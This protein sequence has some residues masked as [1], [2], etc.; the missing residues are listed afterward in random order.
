MLEVGEIKSQLITQ[1]YNIQGIFQLLQ[2][3]H[4]MFQNNNTLQTQFF[5]KNANFFQIF[6]KRFRY[7]IKII[8]ASLS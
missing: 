3:N 2:G 8:I 6:A 5:V 7:R 1:Q 4:K